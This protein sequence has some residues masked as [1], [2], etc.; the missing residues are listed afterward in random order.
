M[1]AEKIPALPKRAIFKLMGSYTRTEYDKKSRK[2][3][4]I[5][6]QSFSFPTTYIMFD[7]ERQENVEVRYA[8]SETPSVSMDG[9][10][11]KR[12]TPHKIFFQANG[13]K[14]VDPNDKDLY[15]FMMN[16]PKLDRGDGT[17]NPSFFLLSQEKTAEQK[18]EK[19][20]L[21]HRAMSMLI[22]E[23]QKSMYE[24]RRLVEAL[25]ISN[26]VDQMND[27]MVNTALVDYAKADPASF[28]KKA[29][30]QEI[31]IK[32]I[33][34]TA[35][36]AHYIKYSVDNRK[37]MWGDAVPGSVGRDIVSVPV[38]RDPKEYFIEWLLRT[39]N[40]GVMNEIQILSKR[41]DETKA[42]T[43]PKPSAG[44]A[45]LNPPIPLKETSGGVITAELKERARNAGMKLNGISAMKYETFIEKLTQ[46]EEKFSKEVA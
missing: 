28:I 24:Q 31:E 2:D 19:Q 26:D 35:E 44:P 40:S 23:H 8:I 3:R 7:K 27:D 6:A 5:N 45:K 34:S 12:Y 36:K 18:R 32:L 11:F 25:G 38:S 37:W 10:Q 29:S 14:I 16:S 39:D 22:G 21:E 15:W 4:K 30:S 1:P 43:T 42:E 20:L 17:G 46:A 33:L 41:Y 9:K 13:M